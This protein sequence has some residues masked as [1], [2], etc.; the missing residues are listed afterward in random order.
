MYT[1][2]NRSGNYHSDALERRKSRSGKHR[3]GME[4]RRKKRSKRR[5]NKAKNTAKL[6]FMIAGISLVVS[7]MLVYVTNGFPNL[8]ERIISRNIEKAIDSATLRLVKENNVEPGK[9]K[10]FANNVDVDRLKTEA[11]KRLGGWEGCRGENQA[12]LERKIYS[13]DSVSTESFEELKEKYKDAYKKIVEQ[14]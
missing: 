1:D 14:K 5:F 3:E 10:D 11:F 8:L 9:I 12:Q 6:L 4:E 2:H 13:T 7:V